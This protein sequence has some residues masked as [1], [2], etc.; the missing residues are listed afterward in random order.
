MDFLMLPDHPASEGLAQRAARHGATRVVP[1]DSGRPWLVGTWSPA[2]LTLVTAGRRRL[3]VF[4]RTRLDVGS[5]ERVLGQVNSLHGLDAVAAKLP[6]AVH[7]LASVDGRVRGQGSVSTARQVFH[8]QVD[9]VTVAA[10]SPGPLAALIG[11]DL[12]EQT[13]ALRLVV[14]AAP[15]PLSLR[16]MWTG[17]DQVPVG[18][19]LELTPGGGHREVRW[20]RPPAADQP[21]SEVAGR[22]RAALVDSVA[23]RVD[24][25]TVGA[26]LSGGLDSTSL[27]F[28][29][30]AA[31]TNLITHHWQARAAANDDTEW[32]RKAAAMLPAARHRVVAPK[33]APT[34][35]EG[36]ESPAERAD[37]VE[38]PL[39]WDRN[40][41]HS[42]HQARADAA[43]GADTHL[44]GVGGDEL[45][46][47]L[48]TYLWSLVREHPL[49]AL[50]EIHHRRVANRW[51]LAATI[52][53]L[54]DRSP[55]ARSLATAADVLTDPP[56]PDSDPGLGWGG[57]WRRLP[58]W[59]TPE[60]AEAVRGMLR[61]A[62]AERPAP[63]AEDQVRHQMI[64]YAV[65]SGGAVRQMRLALGRFGVDWEAPLLDD[66][67]V[68][69][70]LSV[71]IEDRAGRGLYKPV[72]VEAMRGVLPEAILARRTK[73]EYSAE[74]YDGLRRN[75][76]MLVGMCEDLALGRLGLVDHR[77]LRAAT[78][79]PG[80]KIGQL[81]HLE[82]TLSCE[83]WLRSPSSAPPGSQS[84][85][86]AVPMG[87]L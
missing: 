23:V 86:P 78:L 61:A 69:E 32:A 18:H 51:G 77:L 20:W 41:L 59:T 46:S 14:P 40:R 4:G 6:G 82:N 56:P 74:A 11:A 80:A 12:D 36:Q 64:E 73:G 70:T 53:G 81:I 45:F 17:V 48:P 67:V 55:F 83:N 15:W 27:C 16:T 72:L 50:P 37:D 68:E 9:G 57:G 1:H 26:D 66:R 52:R 44:I 58:T 31:G 47:T 29:A 84:T 22:L 54:A 21:L 60:A 24:G 8:A 49:R 65:Y 33:D 38:G 3:A 71:R 85:V 10:D 30:A 42:E 63:L 75:R 5:T 7:L 28:L 39:S 79:D 35:Y 34:W 13:L 25:R 2:D 62:A 43:D 76:R 19:W 87:D